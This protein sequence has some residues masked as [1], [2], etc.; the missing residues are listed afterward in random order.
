MGDFLTGSQ[1]NS[2]TTSFSVVDV[3]A[4]RLFA[5]TVDGD[6]AACV[7]TVEDS[8][9]NLNWVASLITLA[10]ITTIGVDTDILDVAGVSWIRAKITTPS[11]LDSFIEVG[12][13]FQKE[14]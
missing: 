13:G 12:F 7:L 14:I 2:I 4:A 6:A 8:V 9:D 3:K 5:R 1:K 11:T 10:S